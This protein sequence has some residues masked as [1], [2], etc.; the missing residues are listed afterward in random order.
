MSFLN[1][2]MINPLKKYGMQAAEDLGVSPAR[3]FKTL[4]T[5]VDGKPVCVLVPSDCEVS[6]KKLAQA[7]EGKSAKMMP[8][9][10]AEKV[11]GYVLGG[12][13]PLGRKKIT[14]VIIYDLALKFETI[15]INGGGRGLQICIEPAVLIEVLEADKGS[16]VG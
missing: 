3:V 12:I 7:F 4:M 16:I 13:S 14:P 11:T 5:L 2:A 1:I 9:A 10:E 8:P 6:M 15:F